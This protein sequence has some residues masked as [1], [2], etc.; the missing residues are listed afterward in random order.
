MF[1]IPFDVQ[2]SIVIRKPAD[3]VYSTVADFSTWRSW[4]PWLTQEPDSSVEVSGAPGEPGHKQAWSGKK[5][6]SGH[7]ELVGVVSGRTLDYDLFFIKPWKSRSKAAFV[8]EEEGK[9]TKVTWSMDGTLPA[10]MFFMKKK[11]AAMVGG[12]YERGL[13]MLKE[14]LET[15]K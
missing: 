14:L 4:S 15:K 12:D 8:F 13:A 6:G 10:P 2:R 3:L 5:I 1:S 11:M 9:D 7:M